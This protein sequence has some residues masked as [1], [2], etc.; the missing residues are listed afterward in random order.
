MTAKPESISVCYAFQVAHWSPRSKVPRLESSDK[1]YE[2]RVYT[3][4]S[5]PGTWFNNP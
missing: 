2:S 1:F 4:D 3:R 5:W